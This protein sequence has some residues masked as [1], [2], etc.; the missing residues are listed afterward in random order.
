MDRHA[1]TDPSRRRFLGYLVAAPTLAAAAELGLGTTPAH[2]VVASGPQPPELY[3]LNDMLTDAARPTANLITVVVHEDGTASFALPRMEV[4]QGITTSSA[5]LIAE[6]L[7]L[8][9]RK[10]KVTLAE[11]RPELVFNQL[12][13]GSNTTISTYTPIR[14]A[15]AIAKQQLLAA[16][17]DQLQTDVAGLTSRDG[18]I[19]AQ[20]GRTLTYGELA[21]RAATTETRQVEVTLKAT[22]DF[23]VIGRAQNR[24]D[25]R[26][27]VTGTKDFALDLQVKGAKPTMVCRAPTLNGT[28][29]RIRNKEKVLAMP[30]ITDVVKVSTGVAVRGRTF[31]QCIDA[32]RA[33]D[34][35]WA[36]GPVAGE[37][38]RD[39]ARE[40]RAAELPTATPVDN[41]LAKTVEADFT[42]YFRSNSA[43]ETNCAIADVRADRAE[44]WSG[45]KSPITAQEKIATLLGMTPDQVKVHV[46]TGGGSFGRKLFFDGALE[47]AEI[48][49]RMGKPVKLMWHRTDDARVGRVHPMARSRIRA[50]YAGADVLSF[51]QRHTSV[52][53]DNSHGLGEII[54]AMGPSCRSARSASPRPSSR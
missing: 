47:A 15:A 5:M 26:A 29:K 13:G 20:D 1:P 51:E 17:A 30:G 46:V 3:D 16:A 41:P 27:A 52:V 24:T 34:V 12:T 11:A 36:D 10:V 53:T 48:S 22:S 28:P 9:V 7:D 54:T 4:G 39:I 44:I 8:P 50:T 49:Q 21:A 32:I 6:E 2:A 45:L 42:F 37:S 43:L 35:A 38:D 18:V 25:A 23:T 19:T 14:V 31:G 33:L 40:L